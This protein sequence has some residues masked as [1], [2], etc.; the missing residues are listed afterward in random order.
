MSSGFL[1]TWWPLPGAL[2]FPS[3]VSSPP[4]AGGWEEPWQERH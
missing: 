1:G 4:T 3:S 2:A